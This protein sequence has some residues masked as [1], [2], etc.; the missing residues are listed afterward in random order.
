MNVLCKMQSDCARQDRC[1][2]EWG[3]L[4]QPSPLL[5]SSFVLKVWRR[6]LHLQ[7]LYT[8]ININAWGNDSFFFKFVLFAIFL[9]IYFICCVFKHLIL[10]PEKSGRVLPPHSSSAWQGGRESQRPERERPAKILSSGPPL[11]QKE[12]LA[13]YLYTCDFWPPILYFAVTYACFCFYFNVYF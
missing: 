6:K 10:K 2:S 8:G 3:C 12:T 13:H 4:H 7:F 1:S 9:Q 5:S 11:V